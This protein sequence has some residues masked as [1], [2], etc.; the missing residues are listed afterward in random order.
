M[1]ILE[2]ENQESFESFLDSLIEQ[3]KQLS[4]FYEMYLKEHEDK[5]LN[6]VLTI[7]MFSLSEEICV[8][9]NFLFTKKEAVKVTLNSIE[10]LKLSY[11]SNTLQNISDGLDAKQQNRLN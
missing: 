11:I 9:V 6:S 2:I 10:G 1:V 7:K 5:I 8:R 3:I 4:T